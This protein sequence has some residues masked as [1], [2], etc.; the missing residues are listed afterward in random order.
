MTQ[1]FISGDGTPPTERELKPGTVTIGRKSD[2]D[3]RLEDATVSGHHAK[4]VTYFRSSHIEDLDSTNGTFVNGRRVRMHTLHPGDVIMIGK[5]ELRFGAATRK[6]KPLPA[7][8]TNAT[9]VMV[10]PEPNLAAGA[11]ATG[12]P[13][14]APPAPLPSTTPSPGQTRSKAAVPTVVSQPPGPA[15]PAPAENVPAPSRTDAYFKIMVGE[16]AGQRLS[17][18]DDGL[19]LLPGVRVQ[20]EN[21][22]LVVRRLPGLRQHVVRL[23]SQDIAAGSV[24]LKDMDMLQVGSAWMAFFSS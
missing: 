6:A 12:M 10:R 1:I 23:N 18:P 14:S 20:R 4:I 16:R 19:E 21:D 17:V 15:E 3:L 8:D 11:G 2:N 5:Y 9:V 22:K 7:I 13:R 24:A